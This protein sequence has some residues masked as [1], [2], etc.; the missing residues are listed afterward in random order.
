MQIHTLSDLCIRKVCSLVAVEVE[1]GCFVGFI[2]ALE[3]LPTAAA[4]TVGSL[5]ATDPERGLAVAS[6][7]RQQFSQ[8]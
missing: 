4:A 3:C 5:E 6:R 7:Q 8:L 1:V 2:D